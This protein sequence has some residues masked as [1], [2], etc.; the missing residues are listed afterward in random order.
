MVDISKIKNNKILIIVGVLV[1]LIIAVLSIKLNKNENI[2]SQE[3]ILIKN[4]NEETKEKEG[5]K[6]QTED[7]I[8]VHVTGEVKKSGIV[9]LKD[10][11]RI[12]DAINAAGG[13]TENADISNVNLAYVLEDGS[14]LNIPS[15]LDENNEGNIISLDSGNTLNNNASNAEGKDDMIIKKDDKININKATKDQFEKLPGIGASLAE[16]ILTYRKEKGKFDKIEDLKDVSGIGESKFE[17][18]KDYICV[19]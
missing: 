5:D 3:E 15:K 1:I 11:A 13:L 12:E 19:K 2:D 7:K 10:G 14:K 17:N 4:V 8:I 16:R 9:R 6:V 18:I